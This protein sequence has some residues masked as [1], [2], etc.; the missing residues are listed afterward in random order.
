MGLMFCVAAAY[1]YQPKEFQPKQHY[2]RA[3][4]SYESYD[5]NNSAIM[6]YPLLMEN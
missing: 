5:L 6:C 3:D 4:C 2:K 1:F